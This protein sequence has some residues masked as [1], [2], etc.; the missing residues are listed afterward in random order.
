VR[1]ADRHGGPDRT[2]RTVAGDGVVAIQVSDDGPGVPGDVLARLFEPFSHG[3]KAGSLGLGLAV[4]RKLARAMGGDLH[5]RREGET[6]VF[7]L[8]LRPA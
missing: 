8:A 6:T 5:Y 4:S 3:A 7:E 2:L 1:N